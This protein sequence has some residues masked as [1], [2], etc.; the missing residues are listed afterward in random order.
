MVPGA[1]EYSTCHFHSLPLASGSHMATSDFKE[2]EKCN[3]IMCFDGEEPG[4][5]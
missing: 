2:A 5:L 3:F 1:K 4:Y